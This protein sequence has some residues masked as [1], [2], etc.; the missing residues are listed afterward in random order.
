M[1][2][3]LSLFLVTLYYRKSSN[4]LPH[5]VFPKP[6][7]I[8]FQV[9]NPIDGALVFTVST[10]PMPTSTVTINTIID[11]IN[12]N[13][14]G[15]F[16]A[17]YKNNRVSFDVPLGS[18]FQILDRDFTFNDGYL[19]NSTDIGKS[20]F[21]VGRQYGESKRFLNR[22][23]MQAETSYPLYNIN[24]T[25]VY[26]KSTADI[27]NELPNTPTLP[28]PVWSLN[29]SI[30]FSSP[31]ASS[32]GIYLQSQESTLQNWDVVNGSSYTFVGL[33]PGSYSAFVSAVNEYEESSVASASNFFIAPPV[34]DRTFDALADAAFV[35]DASVLPLPFSGRRT[36]MF[37]DKMFWPL[38]LSYSSQI[39]SL[40]I[41]YY[42]DSAF[43]PPSDSRVEVQKLN[44]EAILDYTYNDVVQKQ[45]FISIR[46]PSRLC[47]SGFG[48]N[49]QN[50]PITAGSP[51]PYE[52]LTITNPVQLATIFG[53]TF[54]N[55]DLS[56]SFFVGYP[57]RYLQI[58]PTVPAIS[59]F[60]F[61]YI[62]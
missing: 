43:T 35:A 52:V 31:D 44:E 5:T 19:K 27:G 3:F 61:Q 54:T 33:P 30:S 26:L 38:D 10:F 17:T 23:H 62:A 51:L 15:G 1:L 60:T 37:M 50:R 20:D 14:K 28:D 58:H 4:E 55:F 24:Y 11:T 41:M 16:F 18:T 39:T 49:N 8:Q 40:E 34:Q 57:G 36:V 6:C 9:N 56:I 53:N 25:Y 29:N 22:L 2:V 32:Y 45:G 47:L 42:A 7:G 46:D 12:A 59:S 13:A 21:Y 48:S